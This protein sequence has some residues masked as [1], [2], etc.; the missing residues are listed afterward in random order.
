MQQQHE[1]ADIHTNALTPQEALELAEAVARAAS[2]QLVQAHR[3]REFTTAYKGEGNPVTSA[4]LAVE[5]AILSGIKSV[6]G[7]D[8]FLTEEGFPNLPD[9]PL[10]GNWWIVDPIDGTVNFARGVPHCA[11]SIAYAVDGK[12]QAG[13]V[14]APLLQELFSATLG[15]GAYLNGER[16]KVSGCTE[17]RRALIATGFPYER[18]DL[19]TATT[20]FARILGAV[21]DVRRFGACSLDLCSVACGRVDGYFESVMPWDM[22]AGAL[23]VREGGGMVKQFPLR[24][25]ERGKPNLTALG[26]DLNSE[27][28]IAVTPRIFEELLRKL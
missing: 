10:K 16:I 24:E 13:V 22:A 8:R 25:G 23:I 27:A 17:L 1:S 12:V 20:R 28:L 7:G 15:G 19:T 9:G 11:I 21:Q 18:T 5:E 14:Y 26:E 3:S 2:Q 4:D 6:R